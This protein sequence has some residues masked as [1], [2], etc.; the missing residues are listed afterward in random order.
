MNPAP[1]LVLVGPMGAGKS[2]IGRR[3]AARLGLPFIDMDA[4]IEARAGAAVTKIFE[5][6]GE[7]GFR[8]RERQMLDEA[9]H[10]P[11]GIIAAGG[12]VVLAEDNRRLLRERAFVVCLEIG[13]DGQLARLARDR[14]RPLLQLEDKET[15]LRNLAEA[16]AA[17]YAEVADLHFPTDGMQPGDAALALARLVDAQ[18]QRSEA[19]A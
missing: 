13:I 10:G 4:H 11:S 19:A 1:H 8:A 3:L 5:R 16:R 18:W 14:T 7:A 2:T 12:G 9:L 6:E 15:V 17:L